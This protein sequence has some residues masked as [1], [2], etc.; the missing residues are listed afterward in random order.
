MYYL[1][2]PEANEKVVILLNRK[3]TKKEETNPAYSFAEGGFKT[4]KQALTSA[5][6]MNKTRAFDQSKKKYIYLNTGEY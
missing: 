4:R 2:Y 5:R 1:L 6:K 3:P